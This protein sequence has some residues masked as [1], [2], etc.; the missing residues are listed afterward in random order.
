MR[1]HH[2]SPERRSGGHSS[3]PCLCKDDV[4]YEIDCNYRYFWRQQVQTRAQLCAVSCTFSDVCEP[5]P[6]LVIFLRDQTSSVAFGFIILPQLSLDRRCVQRAVH[7]IVHCSVPNVFL[8]RCNTRGGMA[9]TA[10]T[11]T[12]AH[13]K[14]NARQFSCCTDRKLSARRWIVNA[15]ADA[16]G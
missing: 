4:T 15:T 10:Y 2:R 11:V 9:S 14:V 8:L 13:A 6:S 16:L 7:S 1:G 5:N 12:N 3:E